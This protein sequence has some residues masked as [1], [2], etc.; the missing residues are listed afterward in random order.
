MVQFV[1]FDFSYQKSLYEICVSTCDDWG[2]GHDLFP[3]KQFNMAGDRSV[4]YSSNVVFLF[5]C[6]CGSLDRRYIYSFFPPCTLEAMPSSPRF[7]LSQISSH[8]SNCANLQ[9]LLCEMLRLPGLYCKDEKRV[10]LCITIK[11]RLCT[12]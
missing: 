8:I 9:E 10:P 2:D 11:Q 4:I 1:A 6:M 5:L 3:D 7:A 12:G